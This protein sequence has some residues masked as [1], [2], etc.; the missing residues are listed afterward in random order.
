MVFL[1]ESRCF[2]KIRLCEKYDVDIIECGLDESEVNIFI[3]IL[4]IVFLEVE[5]VVMYLK[6]IYV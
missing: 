4:I 6:L 5:L 3:I 2:V 1:L